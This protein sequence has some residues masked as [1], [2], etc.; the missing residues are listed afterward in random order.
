M[1]I[2]LLELTMKGLRV[3]GVHGLL[4]MLPSFLSFIFFNSFSNLCP[5]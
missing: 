1:K 4:L 3:E 2:V 5:L